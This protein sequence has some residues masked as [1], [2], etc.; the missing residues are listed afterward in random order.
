MVRNSALQYRKIISQCKSLIREFESIFRLNWRSAQPD[1]N[2]K[3]DLLAQ[4]KPA[5]FLL[6]ES[7]RDKHAPCTAPLLSESL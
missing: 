7:M 3:A 1:G 5:Q 6:A 4:S 2:D